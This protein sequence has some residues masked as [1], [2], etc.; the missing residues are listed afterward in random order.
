V[1]VP[2]VGHSSGR[3]WSQG[4]RRVPGGSIRGGG[5][6]GDGQREGYDGAPVMRGQGRTALMGRRQC[7]E[8]ELGRRVRPREDAA[9]QAVLGAI[10]GWHDEGSNEFQQPDGIE[11]ESLQ[12]QGF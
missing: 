5:G 3:R 8:A 12:F 10:A 7:Q 11:C 9:K 6:D 1:V 4:R 2:G